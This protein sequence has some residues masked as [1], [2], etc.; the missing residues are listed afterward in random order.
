MH[1]GNTTLSLSS[2]NGGTISN[3]VAD[4]A[5]AIVN[6]RVG[7]P[8]KE[9]WDIIKSKLPDVPFIELT[10][11][12]ASTNPLK[13]D[14]IRGWLPKK[15]MPYGTDLTGWTVDNLKFLLGVGSIATA[16]SDH[17]VVSKREMI[18]MVGHYKDFIQGVL[19]GTLVPIVRVVF[20][21]RCR[22]PADSWTIAVV[23]HNG[24][25]PSSFEL[26]SDRVMSKREIAEERIKA[27]QLSG[28]MH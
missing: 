27:R 10:R 17:E 18:N 7:R 1:S 26:P 5:V 23:Q 25:F 28:C 8:A 6:A 20:V 14:V 3:Q 11:Q 24:T 21:R 4:R 15:V 22:G 19:N 16:H 9:I 12:S 13:V 2:L